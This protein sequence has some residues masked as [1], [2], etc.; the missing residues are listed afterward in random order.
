[1][2]EAMKWNI[3]PEDVAKNRLVDPGWHTCAI[4]DF[5]IE[6]AKN[7]EAHNAVFTF[8]V[9]TGPFTG[10]EKIIYFSEKVPV[11][12]M[13]LLEALGAKK[14]EDGSMSANLSKDALVTD[15]PI[16][17]KCKFARGE[18]NGKPQNEITE[19]APAA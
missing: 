18:Y 14:N 13:N 8:R 19:Y 7:K 10:A 2:A 1:M 6:L 9:H 17:V 15:P 5:T 4:K 12:M 16:L 11:M 3:T